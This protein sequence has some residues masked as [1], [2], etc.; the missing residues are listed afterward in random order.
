MIDYQ[1]L[2]I[3]TAIGIQET[4]REKLKFDFPDTADVRCI[5]GADISYNKNSN[6]LY[7]AIVTLSYPQLLPQ[8]YAL[9]TAET[10]FPYISGF[11]AF[12]EVPALLKA[13]DYL[14]HKPD[15]VVL[16][17]QGILHP[18]K[19]GIAAHFGV[20]TGINTI[21]CAKSSL[22]GQY[23]EPAPEKYATSPI[24]EKHS[25]TLIGHALRTKNFTKPVYIS[26]GYGLSIAKSLAIMQKC[27]GKYRIPEPTR[28]AHEVVNQFRLGKLKEGFHRLQQTPQLF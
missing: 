25:T 18:R 27:I 6:L 2:N 4:L 28:I 19:M 3:A 26:P 9:A 8:T 7:A 5:A 14:P 12:R 23:Q 11:L 1:N 20:L 16:D 10:D 15:V 21:G 17:G 24:Y 22:Y 13:W